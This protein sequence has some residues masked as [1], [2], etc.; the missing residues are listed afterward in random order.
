MTYSKQNADFL[1]DKIRFFQT[2]PKTSIKFTQMEVNE[3][4]TA[5]AVELVDKGIIKLTP[6]GRNHLEKKGFI[7]CKEKNVVELTEKGT[8]RLKEKNVIKL[9]QG[10]IQ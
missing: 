7:K 3:L 2:L 10:K 8:N 9:T 4:I 1:V 5:D 6:Q